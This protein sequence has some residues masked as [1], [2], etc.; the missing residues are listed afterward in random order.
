MKGKYFLIENLIIYN[1]PKNLI[2][3]RDIKFTAIYSVKFKK[4]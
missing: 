4:K 2:T 3:T 1:N